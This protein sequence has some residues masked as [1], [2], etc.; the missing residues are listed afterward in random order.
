MFLTSDSNPNSSIEKANIKNITDEKSTKTNMK[1]EEYEEFISYFRQSN[2]P[3]PEQ[4]PRKS[5]VFVSSS[6]RAPY[7]QYSG[8]SDQ[9]KCISKTLYKGESNLDD[10]EMEEHQ[11]NLSKSSLNSLN[12]HAA[13]PFPVNGEIIPFDGPLFS[14]IIASRV[15]DIPVSRNDINMNRISK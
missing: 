14:G 11:S 7:I 1:D 8:I 12:T 3:P 5:S 4:W 15:K 13:T 9:D 6:I 10:I 2:I